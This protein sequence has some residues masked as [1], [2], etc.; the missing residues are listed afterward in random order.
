M[1]TR[2]LTPVRTLFARVVINDA[3][4]WGWIGAKKGTAPHLYPCLN[5][6]GR[7]LVSACRLSFQFFNGAIPDGHEVCHRCDN[8]EC[9]NPAH[10]FLGT[11]RENAEDKSRKGRSV[12]SER[13]HFA[14]L[15]AEQV[16]E[17]RRR[18]TRG[19]TQ[20]SLAQS[21][22]VQQ[23]CISKI[24]LRRTWRHLEEQCPA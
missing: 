24:V 22:G 8:P 4:C 21:Y 16:H 18:A 1:N 20:Q 12:H 10:L 6:D 2:A 17:I 15:T 3:D 5:D 13:S 7:R 9:C 19:E 14:H 23:A 11:A